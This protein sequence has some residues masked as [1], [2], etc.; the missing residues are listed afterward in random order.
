[1]KRLMLIVAG[2]LTVECWADEAV[3]AY[4]VVVYGSTPAALSAAISAQRLGKSAV[5]VCGE[6]RIGGLTTGGLGLLN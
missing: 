6:A 3:Q 1:M 5:I 2:L 4:D